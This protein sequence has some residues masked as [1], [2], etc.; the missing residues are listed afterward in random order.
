MFSSK[1]IL[2]ATQHGKEK[3]MQPLLEK[4]F[5]FT[6]LPNNNFDTDTLGTFSGEIERKGD[7][8][9]TLRKKCEIALKKNNLEVVIASE[10]S[11]GAHPSLFFASANDELVMFK[12]E[13]LDIEV[14][15][16]TISLETNF[17]TAEVQTQKQLLEFAAKALFPSHALIIQSTTKSAEYI[18]KGIRSEEELLEKFIFLK[19]NFTN[20]VVSTDMRAMHNPT[21]MKVIAET[22]EKLIQKLK[23]VC[24]NCSLP[25]F[26]VVKIN[27]G[28]IC[29]S[30]NLP[31]NSTLSH[32]Y[33]C[34]KC[35]YSEIKKFPLNKTE[36]DPM[37]CNYCNP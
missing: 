30:C 12:D 29:S 37:Y 26:D 3:V 13:V 10:G 36:E 6:C 20:I 17:D 19:E 7:A 34:K 22:T 8:L 31:T 9:E 2:I 32:Q 25:G 16:R 14:V 35:D 1:K 18:F 33:N 23:S 27:S 5:D 21:R 4:H 15:A 28:L 24:P 11:F